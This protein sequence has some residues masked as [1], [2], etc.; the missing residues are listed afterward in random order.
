[1]KRVR[2]LAA[3]LVAALS[4]G[5]MSARAASAKTVLELKEEGTPVA[6]G[7]EL[8]VELKTSYGS[9]NLAQRAHMSLNGAKKDKLTVERP[10]MKVTFCPRPKGFT[11]QWDIEGG[12]REIVLSGAGSATIRGWPIQIAARNVVGPGGSCS[13]D[14]RRFFGT[15][16]VPGHVSIDGSTVG[17]LNKRES[18]SEQ[19]PGCEPSESTSFVITVLGRNNKPLEAEVVS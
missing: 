5:A 14:F 8:G 17:K 19:P 15:F 12:V 2:V 18:F 7:T 9:C 11:A 4:F 13:Y 3:I 10:A 6:R 16:P 1:M